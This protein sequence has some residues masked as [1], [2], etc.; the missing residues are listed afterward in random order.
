MKEKSIDL[1][2]LDRVC[3]ISAADLSTRSGESVFDPL[4]PVFFRTEG[5]DPFTYANR[6]CQMNLTPSGGIEL[7]RL[8]TPEHFA[9]EW[10]SLFAAIESWKTLRDIRIYDFGFAEAPAAVALTTYGRVQVYGEA[11][12]FTAARTWQGARQIYWDVD[13]FGA[14]CEGD[15]FRAVG[16][17]AALDGTDEVEEVACSALPGHCSP[18]AYLLQKKGTALLFDR[19]NHTVTRPRERVQQ[20]VLV[21]YNPYGVSTW[22]AQSKITGRFLTSE[23]RDSISADFFG[24]DYTDIIAPNRYRQKI[25][26]IAAVP[27]KYLAVLYENGYLRVFGAGYNSGD[28]LCEDVQAMELSGDELI[29]Y[30]PSDL[31]YA[32][33]IEFEEAGEDI[34][35]AECSIALG[36]SVNLKAAYTLLQGR[37]SGWL[38]AARHPHRTLSRKI[39][40]TYRNAYYIYFLYEDGTVQAELLTATGH[41][42]FGENAVSGWQEVTEILPGRFQT[43]ALCR[44][45]SVLSAGCGYGKPYDLSDWR[46][47]IALRQSGGIAAGL[48][49]DG[50][51]AAREV[52]TDMPIREVENWTEITHI[53]LGE[54][55][56][57][58]LRRDGT[59]VAA[60]NNDQGQCEVRGWQNITQIAVAAETVAALTKEGR[61]LTAGLSTHLRFAGM[62][63]WREIRELI[64]FQHGG[65]VF[66][67]LDAKG[68]L[69]LSGRWNTSFFSYE[70]HLDHQKW[71][72]LTHIWQDGYYLLGERTDGT[73]VFESTP[74]ERAGDPPIDEHITDWSGVVDYIIGGEYLLAIFENGRVAWEGARRRTKKR[75]ITDRWQGIEQCLL[76]NIEGGKSNALAVDREGRLYSDMVTFG[77]DDAAKQ[78]EIDSFFGAFRGVHK[79]YLF[80]PFLL[81]QHGETLSFVSYTEETL[82]RIDLSDVRDIFLA[83][84]GETVIVTFTDGTLRSFGKTV[85]CSTVDLASVTVKYYGDRSDYAEEGENGDPFHHFDGILGVQPGG[86]PFVL[87]PENLR[88]KESFYTV[89]ELLYFDTIEGAIDIE[90]M[91]DLLL[92]DGTCLSRRG[93][94]FAKWVG[95]RQLSSC[96]THAV[97]V[98]TFHTVVVKGDGEYGSCSV[99]AYMGVVEALSLPHA[100]VLL[101][102]NGN[103]ISLC[104]KLS[105][106]PYEPLPV[107]TGVSTLAKTNSHFAILCR[108]GTLWSCE[109]QAFADKIRWRGS[110]EYYT[111]PWGPWK[112]LCGDAIRM[113]MAGECIRVWRHDKSFSYM[114][115]TLEQNTLSGFEPTL[116]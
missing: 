72:L 1:T 75:R 73:I 74:T 55:F 66:L 20:I 100:T 77:F 50:T 38:E 83:E 41:S 29:V 110:S 99:D 69:H 33:A 95:I 85:F 18:V 80:Q 111:R 47:M 21:K 62:E 52:D 23:P 51:V 115:P 79:I 12:G 106:T 54:N 25:R 71:S 35:N 61:V 13:G 65:C 53:E 44:D 15:I 86:R 45:G 9:E 28:I 7:A 87:S 10:E 102:D 92:A 103:L 3:L 101:L 56:I 98:T 68:E 57:V 112:K 22:V 11:S 49:R 63:N 6:F 78:Q 93:D 40:R 30:L 39:L 108:D 109:A 105:E 24:G 81:V 31:S 96:A 17:L 67:G 2:A 16:S 8:G 97:G 4:H 36:A 60:G 107:T 59:V 70:D 19:K 46:E 14:L 90:P 27:R 104:E 26:D 34:A 91:G 58:G 114:E 37:I 88:E 113:T 116:G 48:R 94:L 82:H 5:A 43:L 76:W 84:Q 89:Q 42:G 64:S 32:P